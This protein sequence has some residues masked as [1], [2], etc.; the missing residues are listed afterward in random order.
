MSRTLYEILGVSPDASLEEL[1]QA[2]RRLYF[3]YHPRSG[4]GETEVARKLRIVNKAYSILCDPVERAVYDSV[5]QGNARGTRSRRGTGGT[6][7]RSS[8]DSFDPQAAQAA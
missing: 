8:Q 4:N 2:H 7:A 3:S 6:D 5:L 1:R